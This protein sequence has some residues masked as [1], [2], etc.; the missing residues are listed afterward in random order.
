MT[1]LARRK[2]EAASPKTIDKLSFEI[3]GITVA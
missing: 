2:L 1:G 3:T